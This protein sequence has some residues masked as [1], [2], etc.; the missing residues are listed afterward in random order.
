[1]E[2]QDGFSKSDRKTIEKNRRNQMKILCSNLT[3]LLPVDQDSKDIMPLSDQLDEAANYIKKLEN[4]LEKMK[5]KKEHLKG[6]EKINRRMSTT[7]IIVGI[8]PPQIEIHTIG[9]ILEVVLISEI[10]YSSSMFYDI[11]RLLHNEGAEVMNAS[12]YVMNDKTFHTIYS[13]VGESAA[14]ISSRLKQFCQ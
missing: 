12:F 11:I 7:G 13:E 6:I 10:D 9:S 14:R 8:R 4:K 2:K 3:S 5:E 1:M